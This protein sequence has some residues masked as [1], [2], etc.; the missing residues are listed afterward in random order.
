MH[1]SARV[2][3]GRDTTEEHAYNSVLSAASKAAKDS[4]RLG[5]KEWE[6]EV[7]NLRV[8]SSKAF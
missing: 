4:S 7:P 3:S 2:G 5:G 8:R 6:G 1:L